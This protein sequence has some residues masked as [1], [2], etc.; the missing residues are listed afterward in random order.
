ML[1][2]RPELQVTTLVGNTIYSMFEKNFCFFCE[3]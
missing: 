2:E 3:V 1:V